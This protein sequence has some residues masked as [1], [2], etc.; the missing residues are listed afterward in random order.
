[1]ISKIESNLI[2]KFIW[3]SAFQ[4]S[5]EIEMTWNENRL[6]GRHFETVQIFKNFVCWNMLVISVYIY[7][8]EIIKIPVGKW[9]S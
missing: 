2:E 8:V 7:G 4:F 3:E 9:F 6:F 1:M 5:A